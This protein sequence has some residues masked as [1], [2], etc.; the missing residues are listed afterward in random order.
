MWVESK[1][2]LPTPLPRIVKPNAPNVDS[3]DKIFQTLLQVLSRL[4]VIEDTLKDVEDRVETLEDW[5]ALPR[6]S[7]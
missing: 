6:H 1:R 5:S 7:R 4:D 3:Q 2:T